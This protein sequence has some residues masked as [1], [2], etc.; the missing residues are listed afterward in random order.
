MLCGYKFHILRY[1]STTSTNF[2]FFLH[3]FTDRK[4][5]LIV[6]LSVYFFFSMSRTSTFS[7]KGNTLWLLFGTSE[8]HH[9]SCAL[10]LLLSK[11]KVT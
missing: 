11:I 4:V 10:E 9:Y 3:N 2:F 5:I 6:S 8:F 1:D 7:L